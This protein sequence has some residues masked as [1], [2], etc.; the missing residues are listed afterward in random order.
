M[1]VR[2]LAGLLALNVGFAAAGLALLH[3]LRGF[4]TWG[5]ALRLAGLGHLLGIAAFGVLWTE[6]LVVGA[7][8]NGAAVVASLG[9]I[10]AGGIL[11]GRLA[12]RRLPSL[13]RR[14]AGVPLVT[15]VGLA[16]L[17]L[18]LEAL[19]RSARLQGLQAYDAWA[20]WVPK[21]KAIFYFDGLDEGVFTS[22]PGPSYPPLLPILD[23]ASFHAM[24]GADTVT[25][26]VQFWFL[27]AGGVAALAGVLA[28]RVPSWML[29]PSLVLVVVLPRF[30]ESLLLP[31]ADVLVDLFF[32]AGA[33]LVALWLRD[34][35]R[36]RLAVATILLAGAALTKREGLVFALCVVAGAV[37]ASPAVRRRAW[38]E[39]A[40]SGVLVVAAVVPW[41]LWYSAR[42]IA[43]DTPSTASDTLDRLGGALELS[44]DV[45]ASTALWSVVPVVAGVA[46]AA[47]AVW[48]DRRLALFLGIAGALAF[49]GGAWA[50]LG[51]AELPLTAD[52]SVNPIVRY[53]GAIVLLAG[54]STPLLLAS[55]W[56]GAE[57]RA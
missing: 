56:R 41:R 20:F 32:V 42:G 35:E 21:G 26:H 47:C 46:L 25:L 9:L 40:L 2:A 33:V 16:A 6:L 55:A 28:G 48:G 3:A 22:A 43:S 51:Y 10:V 38:L 19:F 54:C 15:A 24:G 57:E 36:W 11:A 49:L 39:A 30:G 23:A 52:E 18:L 4:P 34:A 7:P 45:L 37:V 14:G 29:W 1:T 8:F 13:G 17:G 44:A 50:T 27:A 53:T 12:G 5:S 31:L